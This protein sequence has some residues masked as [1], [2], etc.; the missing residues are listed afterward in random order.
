[1]QGYTWV[2][3]LC[4]FHRDCLQSHVEGWTSSGSLIDPSKEIVE[5][6]QMVFLSLSR[7]HWQELWFPPR[8]CANQVAVHFILISIVLTEM[9]TNCGL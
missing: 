8:W 3:Y 5:I 4:R 6:S 2:K 7:E 9:S 1:M